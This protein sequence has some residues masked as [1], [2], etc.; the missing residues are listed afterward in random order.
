MSFEGIGIATSIE[1]DDGHLNNGEGE[2]VM[3]VKK[4]V[5]KNARQK[6]VLQMVNEVH[7]KDNLNADMQEMKH[8][9]DALRRQLQVIKKDYDR[10]MTDVA[11]GYGIIKHWV[12]IQA[13]NRGGLI[14]SRFIKN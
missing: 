8:D 5:H 1:T 2:E 13:S 10:L 7:A 6:K 4:A 11:T 3:S 12:G 9:E 14:K